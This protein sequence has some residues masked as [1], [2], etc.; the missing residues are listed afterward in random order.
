MIAVVAAV[1]ILLVIWNIASRETVMTPADMPVGEGEWKV[2]MGN[3]RR[4]SP[5]GVYAEET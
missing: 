1:L 2:A 4:I 3:S 5:E